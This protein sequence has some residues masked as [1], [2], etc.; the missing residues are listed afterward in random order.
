MSWTWD[1]VCTEAGIYKAALKIYTRGLF[2]PTKGL[3]KGVDGKSL[4]DFACKA[5]NLRALY[6]TLQVK[7]FSFRPAR[8]IK[9]IISPLKEKFIYLFP[10]EERIVDTLLYEALS[11]RFHSFF[12]KHSYAYKTRGAG[13]DLCQS[14]IARYLAKH[15]VVYIIKRDVTNYFPSIDHEILEEKTRS[16]IADETLLATLLS[17]IKFQ[18]VIDGE[19]QVASRGVPF[20]SPVACFFANLYLDQIDKSFEGRTDLQYFR[21]ADDFLIATPDRNVAIESMQLLDQQFEQLK[22]I[23]K[24]SHTKNLILSTSKTADEVFEYTT[25]I[26]HLGLEYRADKSIGLSRDKQRKI[27]NLVKR[28]INKHA[29]KKWSKLPLQAR[30]MKYIGLAN[31]GILESLKS[32]SIVDYY[33]K[34]VTDENQLRLIDRYIAETVL[35]ETTKRGYKKSNFSIV[36]YETLRKWG[37][38]SLVHRQKLLRHGHIE[39]DFFTLRNKAK[40]LNLE[41]NLNRW[42]LRAQEKTISAEKV[43]I[44]K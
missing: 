35:A 36:S 11:T 42:K 28:S 4:F 9:L 27:V 22:L 15:E 12:S 40:E 34:H 13:V 33:L 39:S 44:N 7:N 14:N 41:A 1:D 6:R 24:A 26:K 25:K 30:T 5:K 17:R 32:V 37:L 10:W 20:G 2:N 18:F 31:R 21:Y 38:L 8:Q 23:S 19:V 29:R 16:L 43:L 3:S